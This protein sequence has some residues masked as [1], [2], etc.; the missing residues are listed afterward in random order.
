VINGQAYSPFQVMNATSIFSLTGNPAM[1]L[2]FGT[3]HNGLPI[4]VQIVS[5]MYA[6]TT[7][8][9]AALRLEQL[10]PVRD[11]HPSI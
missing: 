11:L 7:M 1:T 4:G 5:S 2:R 8:F 9:D 6:E 3:S 10:S